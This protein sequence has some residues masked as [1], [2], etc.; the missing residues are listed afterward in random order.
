M[1][2]CIYLSLYQ[3]YLSLYRRV[4]QSDYYR[5]LPLPQCIYSSRLNRYLYV[6]TVA[7]LH[8]SAKAE[9]FLFL[10]IPKRC[11]HA[12]CFLSVILSV[13]LLICL[14]IWQSA[15]CSPLSVVPPTVLV[16]SVPLL[17]SNISACRL[18]CL[19]FCHAACLSVCHPVH[20][21]IP[22]SF[23][24]VL[25]VAVLPLRLA[26]H[27]AS[28]RTMGH[29]ASVL[30][31]YYVHGWHILPLS[32]AKECTPALQLEAQLPKQDQKRVLIMALGKCLQLKLMP[33]MNMRRNIKW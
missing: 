17:P 29:W 14:S 1:W 16:L 27:L 9:R 18:A 28:V 31:K 25:P 26:F 32:S 19:S 21:S 33:V 20:P 23:L 8:I 5:Y 6:L 15:V 12:A 22:P 30:L 13:C 10:F 2:L 7:K 24:P 11:C 4:F 3:L